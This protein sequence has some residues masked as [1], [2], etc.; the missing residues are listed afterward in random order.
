MNRWRFLMLVPFL[1]AACGVE[2]EEGQVG[3]DGLDEAVEVSTFSTKVFQLANKE[4]AYASE[5]PLLD[6][7]ALVHF[8][9]SF[10]V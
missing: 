4:R 3:E 6:L 1:I 7:P 10:S 8:I 2:G 5:V 9:H